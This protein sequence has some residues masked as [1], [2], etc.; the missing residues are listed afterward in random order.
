MCLQT[1]RGDGCVSRPGD[2][3][4]LDIPSWHLSCCRPHTNLAGH[5]HP[6]RVPLQDAAGNQ[7]PHLPLLF[8]IPVPGELAYQPGGHVDAITAH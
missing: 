3:L 1:A 2:W 5:D 8:N 4:W 7:D 6:L